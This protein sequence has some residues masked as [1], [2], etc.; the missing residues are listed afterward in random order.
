M[1]AKELSGKGPFTGKHTYED[2]FLL[3]NN[4]DIVPGLGDPPSVVDAGKL[5]ISLI[6]DS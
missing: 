1:A 6:K 2:A 3:V 5:I 4:R